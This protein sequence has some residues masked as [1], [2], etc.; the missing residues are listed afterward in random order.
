M[1]RRLKIVDMS[2]EN[3]DGMTNVHMSAFKG[4]SNT[5]IGKNYVKNFLK[6]FIHYKDGIAIVALYNGD[7]AGYVVGAPAGYQPEMNKSLI[8][9]AILGF[10][11]HPWSIFNKKIIKIIISRIKT[12]AGSKKTTKSNDDIDLGKTI[13]L[14]G[15]AVSKDYEGLKIGSALINE[16]ENRAKLLNFETMRL[17]VY[18]DNEKALALYKK[19]GWVELSRS[20]NTITLYKKI[21]A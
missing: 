6:W 7:D 5:K 12:I 1:K 20:E 4:Y 11:T 10:I 21:Y 19:S 15:I 2:E 14:V 13:S 17:S 16:F 8:G 9:T 18:G 3:L